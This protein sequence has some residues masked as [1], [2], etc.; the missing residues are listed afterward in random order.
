PQWTGQVARTPIRRVLIGYDVKMGL[1][2]NFS[3]L[4]SGLFFAV[5]GLL[6]RLRGQ[7]ETLKCD[8]RHSAT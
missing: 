7:H 2:M 6:H 4:I 1:E 8:S 5:Y 3:S